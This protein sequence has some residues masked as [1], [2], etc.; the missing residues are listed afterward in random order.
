VVKFAAGVDDILPPVSSTSV[1][2][3]PLVLLIPVLHLDVEISPQNFE[4]FLNGLNGIL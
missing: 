2:N 3:F 1:A 4:N